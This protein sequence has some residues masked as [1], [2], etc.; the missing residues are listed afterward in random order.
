MRDDKKFLCGDN[1]SEEIRV[2]IG[3]VE[4]PFADPLESRVRRL[5][6][7]IKAGAN[8][9]QTQAVF[10]IPKFTRWMEMVVEKGLHKKAYILASVIP[11]RSPGMARFLRDYVSAIAVPDEIVTRMEKAANFREEGIRIATEIIEALKEMPV[12]HGVH[13]MASGWEESVPGIVTRAG[14]LPRPIL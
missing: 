3:A 4:N 1:I 11:L 5:A 2:F 14:L 13:I 10:D 6:K 7:K 12:V 8:F 9:I